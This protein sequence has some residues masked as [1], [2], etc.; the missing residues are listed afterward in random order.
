MDKEKVRTMTI[1]EKIS[2]SNKQFSS[3][4][5][6]QSTVRSGN[7]CNR[8]TFLMGTGL[9]LAAP[10][11]PSL[12]AAG[13]VK[14]TLIKSK[15][16]LVII[17]NEGGYLQDLFLPEKG[18]GIESSRLVSHLKNHYNELTVL[19]RIAQP[20]I[21]NGHPMHRGLLTLNQN[22]RNGPLQSL[23]QF[24]S[25]RCEQVT[26]YRSF[27][28]GDKSLVWD[29]NS[30]VLPTHMKRGPLKIYN[31]LFTNETSSSALRQKIEELK[32][33]KAGM[34]SNSKNVDYFKK[35]VQ[36][37]EVE[38]AVEAEWM[39][40]PVPKVKMDTE[41]HLTDNHARGY[42]FPFEQHL[43]LVHQGLVHK[44]GQIFVA[45][46][47]YIDKTNLGVQWSYHGLGHNAGK[48]KDQFEQMYKVESH[49]F[50]GFSK[51]LDSL[52]KSKILDDTIV[53]FMGTFCQPGA[54]SRE[55]IPTVLAGGG[56]KHQGLI[57]CK[58]VYQLANLYTTILNQ[59]GI[60][61]DEFAST[62]GNINEKLIG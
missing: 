4:R 19:S 18:K 6:R 10:M 40:K 29:K 38:I 23:D 54:H 33:L 34:L 25:D 45:S 61:V 47:P 46:P 50:D 2:N 27:H 43:E 53:L 17:P 48:S 1:N 21:G 36:E 8:R 5:T 56:F 30:R 58:G 41:L 11:F 20:E 52:K 24:A 13:S 44:R 31:T 9:A 32:L 3:Q 14:K 7:V 42:I 49:L 37:L 59:M 15:K 16:N 60:D 28:M 55:F 39:D 22:H 51:F 62:K 12:S 26:R 35:T 57:E